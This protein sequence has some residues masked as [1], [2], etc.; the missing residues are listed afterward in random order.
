[1]EQELERVLRERAASI[2]VL[3]D[4]RLEPEPS[5]VQQGVRRG[6]RS[7]TGRP[8]TLIVSG[9]AIAALIAAGIVGARIGLLS[10][11]HRS[12]PSATCVAATSSRFVAAL[13]D[14]AL[15]VGDVVLSAAHDGTLLIAVDH[16]GVTTSVEAMSPSG[17][18]S[19][20]WTARAGDRLRAVANPSG[21]IN[22]AWATFVLVPV[23]GAGAPQV[24]VADRFHHTLA[25]V[26]LD[27]GYRVSNDAATAPLAM[28]DTVDLL[29]T[30]LAAPRVQRIEHVWV[31][32]NLKVLTSR[33]HT[34]GVTALVAVG[35]LVVSIRNRASGAVVADFDQPQYR[36]PT[37]PPAVRSGYSFTS[38]N[39][40]LT[41]LSTVAGHHT[42]WEWT[43]GEAAPTGRP[44]PDSF[45][46]IQTAGRFAVA[47]PSGGQ[48]QIVDARA[49]RVIELPPGVRLLQVNSVNAVLAMRTSAGTRYTRIPAQA[50]DTC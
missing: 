5:N 11:R 19:T 23:D 34:S 30:S 36:P 22:D 4:Y 3:P 50:L 26:S 48:Q 17:T 16:G 13:R 38:D 35:G 25:P 43:P 47:A 32:T 45:A 10:D 8:W 24:R 41:W 27:V 14:G 6:R 12:A 20:M 40:T 21:A 2:D 37:V 49:N 33:V 39:T 29:E 18:R 28:S 31:D 9:A 44:L 46:P 42:L 1:M 7:A 15:P